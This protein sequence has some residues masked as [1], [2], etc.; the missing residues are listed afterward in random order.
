MGDI[1]GTEPV[2]NLDSV[3]FPEALLKVASISCDTA[4]RQGRSPYF[5]GW[6]LCCWRGLG[7]F[8]TSSRITA[9]ITNKLVPRKIL[10]AESK[11]CTSAEAGVGDEGNDRQCPES[12]SSKART[13]EG[14]MAGKAEG[15][16]RVLRTD[17]L[18][19]QCALKHFQNSMQLVTSGQGKRT[20]DA[21]VRTRL[22]DIWKACQKPECMVQVSSSSRTS[23]V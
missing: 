22:L 19:H 13:G 10:H 15:D 2:W 1:A 12:M 18:L 3:L 5:P 14:G 6:P 20:P 7:R 8:C 4:R 23:A 17:F 16:V 11:S 21:Q 9:S